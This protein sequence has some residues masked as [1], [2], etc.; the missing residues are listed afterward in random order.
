MARSLPWLLLL[1][2]VFSMNASPARAQYFFLDVND[3]GVC[4]PSDVTAVSQVDTVDVWIDTSKNL[5]GSTAVCGTGEEL[6]ITSYEIVLRSDDG[7]AILSWTN[8]RPGFTVEDHKVIQAG[9]SWLAYSAPIGSAHLTPGKYRLG[10]AGYQH[11][12]GCPQI[13]VIPAD[14][15]VPGG[16]SKF[17]SHCQGS[18]ED[19]YLRLG[20]D[21]D[22]T[23]GVG[24]IC[25]GVES[26]TWGHIKDIYR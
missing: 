8:S 2:V 14:P 22:G 7:S 17:G 18:Q 10:R 19:W 11:T 15:R 5:N 21:F 3:D 16:E 12:V 13:V 4:D 25:D 20:S 26:T 23:C 1:L 6:S 24:S 9:V